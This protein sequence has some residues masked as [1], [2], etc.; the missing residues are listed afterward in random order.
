MKNSF[1][2]SLVLFALLFLASCGGDD[3]TPEP[4]PTITAPTVTGLFQPEG[5]LDIAFTITGTFEAGNV[6][7]AQ[8]SDGN[9]SFS[10]PISIG[11]LNS[12]AAG[13]IDATLPT[14]VANGNAYRIRVVASAPNTTSPD[15]GSNLSI[16]APTMSITSVTSSL[17]II[18]GRTISVST[19]LTGTFAACNG[20]TLQLSD[21]TG[22]FASP[23]SL[24]TNQGT[25]LDPVENA[26]LPTNV[27]SG[28]GYRLRWVSSCPVVTGAPSNAFTIALPQLSPPT[29]TGNFVAG[30]QITVNVPYSGGPWVSPN[31]T[32]V[33][34]SDAAGSFTNP[35]T[36]NTLTTTLGAS[37]TMVFPIQLPV[38]TPVGA[39]YRVRFT[40]SSPQ[41][42]SPTST[43][44]AIGAL[45][46]LT[47]EVVNP[48]FTKMYSGSRFSSYYV[49]R[50][51]RTGSINALND[52]RIEM[53]QANQPF[54]STPPT[55]FA[56]NATNVNELV[57]VG[58]TNVIIFLFDIGNG[59][60]RFR[61][62]A[63]THQGVQ[64]SELTF[65]VGQ[66]SLGAYSGTVENTAYSFQTLK[67]FFNTNNNALSWNNQAFFTSGD[68]PTSLHGATTMRAF[69]T[70]T[71]ANQNIPTGTQ[72][73]SLTIRLLDATGQTM[74]NYAATVSAT[75]TGTPTAYT[76][77]IGSATLTR[78]F[79]SAGT[80]TISVQSMSASF[81]ME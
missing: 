62:R 21:A 22:N 47:F 56:L 75:I 58:S 13:T 4:A 15:N 37:G 27:A 24:G 29:V 53:S 48:V 57:S 30:G 51:T 9:G 76:A 26:A 17:S 25:S 60:R 79:G 66:T 46:T 52:V 16:A 59:T 10:A 69:I 12:T 44:F 40:T 50:V 74:A 6:F 65:N 63:S 5:E 18:P 55:F 33:Q 20:F 2:F 73:V 7:T 42:T 19:T 61:A 14:S 35:T 41:V 39:S 1:L 70:F 34:L 38:N 49:F 72:N 68:A 71:L 8:L 67:A 64:S 43:S 77:T 80:T 78:N 3:E 36:I 45:P 31:T 23:I 81:A 28:S 54:G 32:L 11:T